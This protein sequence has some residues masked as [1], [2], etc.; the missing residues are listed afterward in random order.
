MGIVHTLDVHALEPPEPMI[1]ILAKLSEL[2]PDDTLVVTH[3]REPVP[4]Y[5]HLE[6]AGFSHAIEKLAENQFRLTIR[7]KR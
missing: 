7:K 4:L 1:R 3:H 5:A 6:A 2:G